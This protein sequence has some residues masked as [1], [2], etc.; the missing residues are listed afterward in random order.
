MN[1][2]HLTGA[3]LA[4]LLSENF[5]LVNT[6][7][8]GTRMEAF[9][10]PR[11]ARRAGISVL[12]VM[13]ITVFLTWL[14]DVLVLQRYGLGHFRTLS[15]T[16]IALITVWLLRKFL[17][18][19]LPELSRRLD[20]SLASMSTNCAALSAAYL[21]SSRGYELGQAVT[22]AFF[23]GLGVLIVLMSFAGLREAVD[24][25]QCPRLFR[26]SPIALFTLGLMAL[27]LVGF[28]GLHLS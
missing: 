23:G 13:V 15:F 19:C 4:A 8:V 9:R 12:L 22:Y 2:V 5:I 10:S 14:M 6:L 11:E 28:Y 24:F 20:G 25:D 16:V 21:A 27:A 7:G 3:A 18:A 17:S 1:P 26:G